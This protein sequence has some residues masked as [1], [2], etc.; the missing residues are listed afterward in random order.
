M[1]EEEV[2]AKAQTMKSFITDDDIKCYYK[3]ANLINHG[4]ILD[5]GTG[6]GK[7]MIALGLSNE[8]NRVISCDTGSYPIAQNWA[9]DEIEYEEKINKIIKDFN[10]MNNVGFV[11]GAAEDF[12][13]QY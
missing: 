11:L 2:I 3:Y 1:T 4:I 10:L 12:V 13:P 8:S 7:S 5:L 6:W 9:E